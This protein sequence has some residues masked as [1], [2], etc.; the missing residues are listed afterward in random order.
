MRIYVL[1]ATFL[2]IGCLISAHSQQPLVGLIEGAIKEQGGS[3]IADATLRAINIDRVEPDS[4]L[5]TTV[6]DKDGIYQ[7]VDVPPGRY[8]ILVKRSGYRDYNV[9][10]VNVRPG[11]TVKMPVI[12]MSP[13]K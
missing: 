9:S 8:S 3:P 13:A 7:F 1:L 10:L 6:T 11:Q 5:R 4:P 2:L 12:K